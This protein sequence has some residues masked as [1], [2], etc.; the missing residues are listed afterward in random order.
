MKETRRLTRS[1]VWLSAFHQL[2]RT[3]S[4]GLLALAWLLGW[5]LWE[6]CL[7]FSLVEA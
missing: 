1:Q 5:H 2:Q 7:Y 3:R 6:D 4:C